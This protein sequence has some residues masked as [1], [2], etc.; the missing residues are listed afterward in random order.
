VTKKEVEKEKKRLKVEVTPLIKKIEALTKRIV[1]TRT[2]GEYISVFRG[3]GLEFDGYKFYTPDMDASRIDWKASIR[4]RELLVKFYR[5]I[6]ELQ[7]YFLF[8]VSESMVFGSTDKLKNE[9]AV[10]FILALAYTIINAG[11]SVG[12]ITFSDRVI[13]RIRAGKGIRQFYKIASIL[14]DPTLYGGGYNLTNV[15]E[16]SL[17]FIK[18]KGS[19]AIIVSDF[20][21][22][23]GTLWQRKLKLMAAK[24]DT[25]CIVVRDPRDKYM[26]SDV[27]EVMIEDPYTGK[28]LLIDAALIKQRYESF[29]KKQ[30]KALFDAFEDA[31]VD[32]MELSTDKPLVQSL[33]DFFIVRRRKLR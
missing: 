20:Y 6:R 10:E 2:L 32:A 7:V 28:R 15:E 16:F 1:R 5:E 9:Y 13:H 22:L 23:K 27:H 19:L 17:G 25:V 18:K 12:L 4:A 33:I 24:F 21:G 29:T 14:L 11:D 26:P 31:N 3:A 30:D 8:D